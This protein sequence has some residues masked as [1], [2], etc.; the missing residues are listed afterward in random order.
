MESV[1]KVVESTQI[2][3]KL[4]VAQE[5]RKGPI[6][7]DTT[8]VRIMGQATDREAREAMFDALASTTDAYTLLG[9][10]RSALF[11]KMG[12]ASEN[13]QT[14]V[15]ANCLQQIRNIQ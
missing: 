8:K 4:W 5:S 2:T 14:A 7:T 3:G 15:V 13:G 1:K 10:V 6:M 12:V 11:R 9:E